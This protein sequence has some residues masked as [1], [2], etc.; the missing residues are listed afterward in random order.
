MILKNDN[1]TVTIEGTTFRSSKLNIGFITPSQFIFDPDAV[2]GFFDG[3]GAKRSDTVRPNQWG[4]FSETTLL[5]AR[6]I[7]LTGTAI[8]STAQELHQLRDE[9]TALLVDGEYKEISVQNSSEVRYITVTVDGTPSWV[10]KIDTAAVWKLELYAPDPRMYGPEQ[11]IQIT[12]GTLSGGIN[13]PLSYPL[14]FG[15]PVVSTA[16]AIGNNGNTKSWPI[17]KVTGDYPSGFKIWDGLN[18]FITYDGVVSTQAPVTIDTFKGAAFQNGI[19][20]STAL[21][22]RDWFGIPP[23]SSIA[24]RFLPIQDSFGWCDIIF[25]DTWI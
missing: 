24:P 11:S 2:Q 8:A 4:D 13:F 5:N 16:V 18:S 25:R 20:Q 22:Q 15:G 1:L 14:N 6:R 17:F 19:D 12:D 23:K 7:T 21:S 10:Q 3:V 9:F